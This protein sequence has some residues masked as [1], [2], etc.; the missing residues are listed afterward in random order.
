[1]TPLHFYQ[2]Q[3]VTSSACSCPAGC[4]SSPWSPFHLKKAIHI[5]CF[6]LKQKEGQGGS[7]SLKVQGS[8]R[9]CSAPTTD[10]RQLDAQRKKQE[11]KGR[12]AAQGRLEGTAFLTPI[13]LPLTSLVMVPANPIYFRY[14]ILLNCRQMSTF[15]MTPNRTQT[16]SSPVLIRDVLTN[17]TQIPGALAPASCVGAAL[18][19]WSKTQ[20]IP[21][22]PRPHADW[23]C[24]FTFALVCINVALLHS[25]TA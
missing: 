10:G 1:M 3:E 20:H 23:Y 16:E 18:S 9:L 12:K 11:R 5:Y 14:I 6:R 4:N 17:L 8:R 13:D 7:S 22:H 2:Q 24:G 21:S 25:L 15:H 19:V